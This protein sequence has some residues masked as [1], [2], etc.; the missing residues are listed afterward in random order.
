MSNEALILLI[1]V[2]VLAI[3]EIRINHLKGLIKPFDGDGNGAPGG[4]R[5][6]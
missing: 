2:T 5:K 3:E 1:L 6:R 4:R